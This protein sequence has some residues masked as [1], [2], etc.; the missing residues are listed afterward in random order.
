M[1]ALYIHMYSS[2]AIAIGTV[3]S[4][5]ATGAKQ[6]EE[7]TVRL[8]GTQFSCIRTNPSQKTGRRNLRR[9]ET[10]T[11]VKFASDEK[12]TELQVGRLE[13]AA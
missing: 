11:L 9:S 5:V 1:N 13:R 4:C 6:E 3:R 8:C 12:P 2:Q 10:S 7:E